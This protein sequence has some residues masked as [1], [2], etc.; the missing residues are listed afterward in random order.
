[1][2]GHV[3]YVS[4]E[5]ISYRW[6]CLP[7]GHEEMFDGKICHMGGHALMEN[8]YRNPCFM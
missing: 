3:G 2:G 5:D 8:L 4:Y 6:I 7:G 1:M